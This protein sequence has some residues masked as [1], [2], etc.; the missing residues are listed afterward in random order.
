MTEKFGSGRFC[1]R[2]CANARVA[3]E[4]Q[5]TS[6]SKQMSHLNTM[7]KA[8]SNT[9]RLRLELDYSLHPNYCTICGNALDWSHRH[10]KTCSEECRRKRLSEFT[11]LNVAKHDGNLNTKNS[12][13]KHGYYNGIYCASSYELAF[14]VYCLEHNINIKR[15]SQGFIYQFNGKQHIYYPDFIVDESTYIE[16]KGYCADSVQAKIDY[17]PKNLK[18][19]IIYKQEMKQYLAY[20]IKKYGRK[21]WD[22][23]YDK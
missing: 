11:I 1:C 17:F 21:F 4:K 6:A 7:K 5:R 15:N 2:S 22:T 20:C 12:G 3:S 16:T 13:Y 10:N 19:K 9:R 14:V 23:L 8:R 18:Y